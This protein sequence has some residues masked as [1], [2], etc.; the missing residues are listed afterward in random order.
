MITGKNKDLTECIFQKQLR[1]KY[2]I[3]TFVKKQC[4]KMEIKVKIKINNLEF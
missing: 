2:K 4:F 3:F 1:K